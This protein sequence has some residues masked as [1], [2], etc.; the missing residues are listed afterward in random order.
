MLPMPVSRTN[1]VGVAW[2]AEM[3]GRASGETQQEVGSGHLEEKR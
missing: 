3:G 1:L 2:G